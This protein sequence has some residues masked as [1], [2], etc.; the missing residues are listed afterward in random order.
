VP[1]DIESYLP[2]TSV[3]LQTH[4][5]CGSLYQEALHFSAEVALFHLLLPS[6]CP[7]ISPALLQDVHSL[8]ELADNLLPVVIFQPQ[9][10]QSH[11]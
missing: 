1:F 5:S 8:L 3:V 9:H 11:D 4:I 10:L 6:S 7:V 2:Q